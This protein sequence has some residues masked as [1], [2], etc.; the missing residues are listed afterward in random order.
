MWRCE[1]K[2]VGKHLSLILIIFDYILIIF[3]KF[4]SYDQIFPSSF[5]LIFPPSSVL[6]SLATPSLNPN[7]PKRKSGKRAA[8]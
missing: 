2:H 7:L 5:N 4:L 1:K 8:E 6:S 3:T